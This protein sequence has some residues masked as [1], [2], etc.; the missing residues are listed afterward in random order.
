[1]TFKLSLV[2]TV[3]L[4]V[5]TLG[6]G[7]SGNHYAQAA[8][9]SEEQGA[10]GQQSALAEK[11]RKN[12]LSDILATARGLGRDCYMFG[13]ERAQLEARLSPLLRIKIL[14]AREA[15]EANQIQQRIAL[16]DEVC[17]TNL[18]P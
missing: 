9:L 6:L 3:G 14:R 13:Q 18:S 8:E 16:L 12:D 4:F 10:P 7:T 2:S 1:M 11:P 15:N 17:L 5:V